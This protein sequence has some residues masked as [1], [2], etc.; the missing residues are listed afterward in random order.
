MSARP[1]C[2]SRLA[3]RPLALGFQRGPLGAGGEELGGDRGGRAAVQAAGTW[4]TQGWRTVGA[5]RLPEPRGFPRR[6]G[7]NAPG[8]P[9]PAKSKDG[10]APFPHLPYT[11]PTK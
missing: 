3:F 4:G 8:Q 9:R 6:K 11:Y 7:P 1:R 2:P 5:P 10:R